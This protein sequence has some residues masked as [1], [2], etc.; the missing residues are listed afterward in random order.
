M[1]EL[2]AIVGCQNKRKSRGKNGRKYR[3]C[4]KHRRHHKGMFNEAGLLKRRRSQRL[5]TK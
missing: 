2:C 1:E 5:F 4:A 3:Q